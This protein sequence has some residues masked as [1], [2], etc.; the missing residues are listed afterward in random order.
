MS[1]TRL[2]ELNEIITFLTENYV[3][4]LTYLDD[5]KHKRKRIRLS[6]KHLEVLLEVLREALAELE[7][8]LVATDYNQKVKLLRYMLEAYD[9]LSRALKIYYYETN[10]E[11]GTLD[12]IIEELSDENVPGESETERDQSEEEV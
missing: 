7:R 5:Y 6:K 9:S 3:F 4:G 10:T 2:S 1:I 8:I 12:G 11:G